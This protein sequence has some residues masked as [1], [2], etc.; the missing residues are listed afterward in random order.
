[1]RT[2][3]IIF[4]WMLA[5]VSLVALLIFTNYRQAVQKISLNK[6]QIQES[7][8]NFVN[9]QTVLNYLKD[10]SLRFD[11]MLI[12][13]FNKER[14]ENILESHPAIKEAEVFTTQK[15]RINIFIKQ[16]Q[17]IVRIKSNTQDYFLDEYGEKMQLSYNYI[18]KL[19]V[20]TGD[21]SAKNHFAIYDFIQKINKSEF[22][23][24]QITQIHFETDKIL[25]I[26]R[27]GNQKINIGSFDNIVEKLDNLYQFYKVVMPVKG[28]QAY[29]DI[30][31]NFKNQIVCVRK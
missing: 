31:L 27:V 14:L 24:S 5:I 13:D 22:W 11:S 17:A 21:V 3:L 2:V 28:W 10:K 16:K 30:N 6:I 18:P 20:A 4:K 9:T 12:T 8:D 23:H 1:M 7:T 15:G 26:P 29:S 19:V 25:L